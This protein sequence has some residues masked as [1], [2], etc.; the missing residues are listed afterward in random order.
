MDPLG[1]PSEL[2][3]ETPAA[4]TACAAVAAALAAVA[5]VLL[6][7]LPGAPPRERRAASKE[8]P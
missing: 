2:C 3:P 1:T 6:L 8:L 7:R 4:C 5:A